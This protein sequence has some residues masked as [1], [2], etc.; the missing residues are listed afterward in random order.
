MRLNK[1]SLAMMMAGALGV[2][3]ASPLCKA[4][5]KW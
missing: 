4:E 5:V 2:N 1:L 3:Y